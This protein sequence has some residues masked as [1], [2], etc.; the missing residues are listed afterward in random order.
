MR[1]RETQ[2]LFVPLFE[3]KIV[4]KPLQQASK[5]A[6]QHVIIFFADVYSKLKEAYGSIFGGA[7]FV[8][9]I[10]TE[11]KPRDT[12]QND[13]FLHFLL[14]VQVQKVSWFKFRNQQ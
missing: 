14:I 10:P 12:N 8:Q 6:N 11:Q 5:Y 13:T 3:E 2:R 9:V 4:I 7:N 1:E